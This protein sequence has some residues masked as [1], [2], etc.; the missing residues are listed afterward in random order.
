MG[1]IF[2]C[3]PYCGKKH[4]ININDKHFKKHVTC[5]GCEDDFKVEYDADSAIATI[6]GMIHMSDN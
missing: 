4:E 1:V 2:V 3:C 5:W 6:S